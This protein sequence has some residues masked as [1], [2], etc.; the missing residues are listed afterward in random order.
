MANFAHPSIQKKFD[1]L[2]RWLSW[3]ADGTPVSFIDEADGD[4]LREPNQAWVEM[5]LRQ[6]R[7]VGVDEVRQETNL[8][9]FGV[10]DEINPRQEVLVGQRNLSFDLR[11]RSRSQAVGASGWHVAMRTQ[12]RIRI[13]A[14]RDRYLGDFDMALVGAPFVMNMP[15]ASLQT[16]VVSVE[17]RV[18]NEAVME[19][20]MSTSIRE[21]DSSAIGSW[22]EAVSITENLTDVEGVSNKTFLVDTRTP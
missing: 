2:R 6:V 22:I 7:P 18:E 10:E 9:V 21:A 5:R 19:L 1:A 4:R 16:G 17:G 20:Q 15:K 8:D 14:A 12:A 3:A 11:F 13:P